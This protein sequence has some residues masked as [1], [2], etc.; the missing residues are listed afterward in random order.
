MDERKVKPADSGNSVCDPNVVGHCRP[1][2]TYQ[3]HGTDIQWDGRMEKNV[4]HGNEKW[5][6]DHAHKEVAA[7]AQWAEQAGFNN[8]ARRL[9]WAARLIKEELNKT[10][11][12][13]L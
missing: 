11:T 3:R 6:L 7:A 4:P 10:H 5:T 13:A 8:V 2:S 12:A 1:A 9:V